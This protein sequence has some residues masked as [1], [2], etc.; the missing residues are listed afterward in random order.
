MSIKDYLKSK[1]GTIALNIIAL[2]VLSLF[3]LSIGNELKAILII[4]LCWIVTLFIY[5][6]ISYKKRNDYF[7]LLEKSIYN[8]DKK[9]LI[10]EVL[11]LP[12]FI[13]AEPYYYLLKK[14][15]KSMREEINKE[16]SRLK[17]Y[18]E[19]IEQWIHEVKTPISLI[20][21]IEENNRTTKSSAIL[22]EI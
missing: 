21:L 15:S 10:S 3:L 8:I 18:K 12:P 4:V 11:E 9:Y 13:E 20:K 7:Q 19:Y 5:L 2:I 14:S 16:K 1:I 17:N 22:T 6:F